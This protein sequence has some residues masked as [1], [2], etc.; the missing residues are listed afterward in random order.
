M[1]ATAI[2]PD[3]PL[4][5][6]VASL[7]AM[8]REL[9]AEVARL[10][11]E[12]A[13]LKTKLDAAT[14]HRFGRRSERQ[15][16]TP[17]AV[18]KPT[19]RRDEHGRQV[20]PEHLERRDVVHDLT[21]QQKL[22]PVCGRV[23]ECI[24]EQTAEQLDLD[25]PRFFVLQTC[26]RSYA[27]RHCDP[28]TVPS[29]QRI[30]TAGPTQVG[31]IAKGL[32][33]PGLLAH[34][35]TAKFADHLPIH[36][37]AGQLSRS[38][39]AIARSTLGDWLTQ[40][41]GLLDPLVQLMHTR[42]LGSRV[43]HADDTPVKLRVA[44]QDRTTKAHLWVAIGDADYPYV[45]FDFTRDYTAQGPQAFFGSYAG[46]LQA[47]ALAQ[48]EQLYGPE[49][50]KHVCCWAHARRKFVTSHEAGDERASRALELI[51][52]LY[53]IERALPPLL[54]PTD[55]P[56]A[57]EQR[58]LRENQRR[59][60]RTRESEGVLSELQSWLDRTRSGALPKSPL[61]SAIGY[62]MNNWAAL[63]RYRDEGYLAIDNNLAERALRAVAVGRNNWGVVGSEVGG[64][65]AATLYS[66]VGTCKHLL[67]D[68]WAYLREALPG[69][70]ALGEESSVEQ[71]RDWLPDRWLL[72]RTRDRPATNAS[73]HQS[74]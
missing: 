72:N 41:A 59:E 14:R 53:A 4:P 71:L 1:D 32:C 66:I 16:L 28:T 9:L 52:K 74:K 73:P 38:G 31:P 70:F 55:N 11:A 23:R 17:V 35:V 49:R 58:R 20:L 34:V 5:T 33:G 56:V 65:T 51:G 43:I 62:T 12:N 2:A 42:L 48:Y 7:Q 39:V 50:I 3:A 47:D 46:Y 10:R 21:D 6:D 26:K 24:G 54:T 57:T 61:G 30:A 69:V 60:I 15:K 45:V 68:P 8:V 63:V 37:L 13:E 29:E 44:K 40:A 19:R 22:C 27:C 67:I 64:R 36:R 18:E 25:P